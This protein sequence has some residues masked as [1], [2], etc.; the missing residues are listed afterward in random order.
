MSLIAPILATLALWWLSTGI[1]LVLGERS[2]GAR[3]AAMAAAGV[4]ALA[5]MAGVWGLR[6]ITAPMAAYA[7]ALS[8]LA[9]WA[10]HEMSFLFG[11][12]T[13]PNRAPCPPGLTGWPR[14]RA[15][16]AT[17]IHHE[18]ALAAT[19]IGL[20]V[21]SLGAA[22]AVAF[23]V[24]ALLFVLRL[25]SKLNL[26][27]A[28]PHFTDHFLPGRLSHLR[29][30]FSPR[31]AGA[32]FAVTTAAMA[33]VAGALFWAAASAASPFEAAAFALLATLAAL[34]VL[35]HLFLALPVPDG[36]LWRWLLPARDPRRSP[37]L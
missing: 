14:F 1:I 22:N 3:R 10:W 8:A 37:D 7:G 36:A 31:P 33:V 2:D 29:S 34:G 21:M 16:A 13:G 17:L 32:F 5:G 25:S 6:D 11:Y 20:G 23:Q 12:V 27:V 18:L 30:Y 19:V 15:A 35:E 24:F 26:F 4:L 9:I 28:A